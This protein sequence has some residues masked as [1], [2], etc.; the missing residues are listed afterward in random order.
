VFNFTNAKFKKECNIYCDSY[1][2]ATFLFRYSSATGGITIT[3]STG[4]GAI[5]LDLQE[6]RVFQTLKIVGYF[7]SFNFQSLVCYQLQI[8]GAVQADIDAR[9]ITCHGGVTFSGTCNGDANFT[10]SYFASS[11]SFLNFNFLKAA[12]F[13][14]CWFDKSCNFENTVFKGIGDFS[15]SRFGSQAS[16]IGKTETRHLVFDKA[17][18]RAS[19]RFT[20]RVFSG[21][22]SCRETVFVI[23]P[24]FH[25]CELHQDTSFKD[26]LFLDDKLPE[27]AAAYRTLKL[28]M[29]TARA[30]DEEALFYALEQRSSRRNMKGGL[31]NWVFSRLYDLG[32]SYGCSIGKPIIWL[33]VSFIFFSLLYSNNFKTSELCPPTNAQQLSETEIVVRYQLTQLVRPFDALTF[34]NSEGAEGAKCVVPSRLAVIS[35]GQTT[36]QL[37]LIALLILA[38]RRRFK[39]E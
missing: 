36:L 10:G 35:A 30:K 39:M 28:A 11:T 14:K 17:C 19:A 8:E 27:A 22:L 20:N 37:S 12:N 26:A 31:I 23:A 7:N 16:W 25:G 32:S 38:I 15:K 24:D 1:Q 6:A 13:K 5:D 9:G 33:A 2:H 21:P 34:R 18:F 4:I 3:R 29:E